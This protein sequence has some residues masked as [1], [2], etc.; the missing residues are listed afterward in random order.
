M[1][2][3]KTLLRRSSTK[4]AE[5]IVGPVRVERDPRV[6]AGRLR[7][8]DIAVIDQ[9]DLDRD[10]AS[11]LVRAGAAAVVNAS[12]T[13]SGRYPSLGAT[14]LVDA[15]V[16]LLDDVG[17]DAMAV[18]RESEKVALV[19]DL[20]LRGDTPVVTGR[21]QDAASVTASLTAAEAGLATQMEAFAAT[22]AEY[23]RREHA[24][25]LEPG[26]LPSLGAA[27]RDRDVLVVGPGPEHRDDLKQLRAWAKEYRPVV[28]AVDE[29][30][31]TARSLGYKPTVLVGDLETVSEAALKAADH[32]VVRLDGDATTTGLARV[33]RMGL[34][35]QTVSTT[36]APVD[37]ALLVADENEARVV[38][39]AGLDRTL[40]SML[41][42]G[43]S[44]AAGTF[45]ARLRVGG[46]LVDA[47]AVARLHRPRVSAG[48]LLL[49]L[50]VALLVL[51]AA[52]W[53]T[54]VGQQVARSVSDQ[55]TSLLDGGAS[56]GVPSP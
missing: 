23:L 27:L 40:V 5:G 54:P 32:L 14:V 44:T 12:P 47:E 34:T 28:V 25:L 55:V 36:A 1:A 10:S 17:S 20:L 4:P 3:V 38:V 8:G 7:R 19:G 45:L 15:G 16:A 9:I 30:A 42:T 56:P 6:L 43:R 21:R 22:A 26:T 18:L 35:R 33:D 37:L 41:D 46:R 51:A 48:L 50:L 52:V 13:V 31:D 24:L 39:A 11:L 53:L 29:A 2:Q 49:L